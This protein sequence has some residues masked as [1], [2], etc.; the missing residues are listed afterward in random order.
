MAV[1]KS[2]PQYSSSKSIPQYST[3]FSAVVARTATY[4]LMQKRW[5]TAV[6]AQRLF[7]TCLL[8]NKTE[9]PMVWTCLQ[10]SW[11]C[12]RQI[13]AKVSNCIVFGYIFKYYIIYL[14]V[15]LAMFF[16][17]PLIHIYSLWPSWSSLK[18]S[19]LSNPFFL[20][21]L[22]AGACLQELQNLTSMRP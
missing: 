12:F 22:S 8:L 6:F 21:S 7:A 4:R 14:L 3:W 18:T 20:K 16:A 1:P 10:L 13:P 17:L 11:D 9:Y 2:Y 5:L 19:H 15:R